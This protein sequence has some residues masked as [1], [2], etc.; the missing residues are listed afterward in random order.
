MKTAQQIQVEQV[1]IEDLRPYP[2]NPRRISDQELEAL[3]CSIREF[4]LV[5]PI[6]ARKE[7]RI[8]IGG[9]QRLLAARRLGYHTV[10]VVLVDLSLEQARLLNIALNKISGSFDQELLARLLSELNE[11]PELDLTLSG[12]GEDELK[13]LLK[14]LKAREKRER[15]ETFDLE[16]AIKAAQSAPVAKQGNLWL[17]GDHRLICGDSADGE[18]VQRLMGQSRMSMAFTDPPYNVD[19]GN[20]GGA[21]Q[22]GKRT[23]ENDNLGTEFEP[24]LEKACRN[25]LDFTDGA[26]YICMSSSELHTL[27]RAFISVGGHWSTFIIW[28][29]NTFTVGRSDYQRQYEPILYG[30]REGAKRNWCG[31]RNQGDVW[32][33]EKPTSN[34]LHPTMKPLALVERAIR[35]SSNLGDKVLD[36]FLGSGS[37]LI[38][39]ERTG[40]VCYGM[41]I[42]PLYV[43]VARMRWENFTGEKARLCEKEKE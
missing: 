11:I 40:R 38:A 16:E 36:L 9:H 6:I 37:T 20:H 41:E 22:R 13:E 31:D 15:V 10:P 29:K 12:F 25:I 33:V 19:Y 39:C 14:S 28:A 26:V 35:N 34:P 18:A 21:P 1:L 3:T 30:W 23:V 5:D 27:H 42:E 24:F 8:V 43:D 2:A 4:G 17:L 7:D 32:H